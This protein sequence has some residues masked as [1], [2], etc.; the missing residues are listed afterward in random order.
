MTIRSLRAATLVPALGSPA[1]EFGRLR[2]N[3]SSY[4]PGRDLVNG[5]SAA[6]RSDTD[7]IASAEVMP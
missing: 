7:P 2:R 6:G 1:G 3:Q 5:I 4:A